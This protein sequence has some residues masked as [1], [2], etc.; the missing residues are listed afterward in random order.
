VKNRFQAFAFHKCNLYRYNAVFLISEMNPA[1][2]ALLAGLDAFVQVAC[3]RWGCAS[4]IQL[5]PYRPKPPGF[6]PRA[7]RV[8][9]ERVRGRL[10]R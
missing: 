8:K 9:N 2:M 4:S 7:Y 6:N 10:E 1:K 5:D 3:P